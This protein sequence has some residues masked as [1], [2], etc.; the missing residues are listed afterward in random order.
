MADGLP[1]GLVTHRQSITGEISRADGV[2][3]E[4]IAY[5][6]KG[7]CSHGSSR[8]SRRPH[9]DAPA[10]LVYSANK[11][12][13]A[14]G[15]GR[16]LEN[17]FWRIWSS[18]EVLHRM[19]GKQ[20]ALHFS[21]ISEGG[22][23][24][25][26]PTQSP[27]ISRSLGSHQTGS[28][29]DQGR[30]TSPGDP[31][32]HPARPHGP[33]R[34]EPETEKERAQPMPGG[35][36]I[37]P[38]TPKAVTQPPSILKKSKAGVTPDASK[39]AKVLSPNAEFAR[40]GGGDAGD[41]GVVPRNGWVAHATHRDG[42]SLARGL[43]SSSTDQALG[44]DGGNG[45]G[46]ST[47]VRAP[48]GGT[49]IGKSVESPEEVKPKSAGKRTVL[50]K[51][52]ASKRR[53]IITQRKSSQSSSSITSHAIVSPASNAKTGSSAGAPGPPP[54]AERRTSGEDE[55]MAQRSDQGSPRPSQPHAPTMRDDPVGGEPGGRSRGEAGGTGDGLVA[56][57]FRLRF[58]ARTHVEHPFF[59][60]S[61]VKSTATAATCADH[62]AVGI[63]EFTGP[64]VPSRRG[65]WSENAHDE[66]IHGKP[67]ASS[68]PRAKDDSEAEPLTRTKSQL[69]LLLERDRQRNHDGNDPK[70][71]R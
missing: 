66:M 43:Q 21:R 34:V 17:F 71:A 10:C 23:F 36:P 25:T 40:R 6:W 56:R 5:L 59:A 45:S 58:A 57:D 39:T 33:V 62:Q 16:R 28:P 19:S 52:A 61:T 44:A 11:A 8:A 7:M 38:P 67:A 64:P 9:P 65:K 3:P 22:Y 12:V 18:R 1:V 2:E 46:S 68:G 42:D 26:T 55:P 27:R 4:D 63:T 47:G 20:V 60:P 50:A 70:V 41:G 14:D 54:R 53:P 35:E 69:T 37:H 30:A 13:I 24:R 49:V 48:E 15:V 29:S 32:Q 31:S 51:T